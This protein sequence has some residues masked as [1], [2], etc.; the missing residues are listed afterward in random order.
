VG[1]ILM[2]P[3]VYLKMV[4]HKLT[5]VWAYSKVFRV[6]RA[7][8]FTYFLLFFFAGPLIVMGNTVI[9]TYYFVRHLLL[10]ELQK[11]KHKTR[12]KHLSKKNLGTLVE[13]MDA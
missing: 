3:F 7:D 4:F 1:E 13:L 5:M 6:S 9:D 8:K 10:L 12:H 2:W 11:V